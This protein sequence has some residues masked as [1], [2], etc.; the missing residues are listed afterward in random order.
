[1][2]QVCARIVFVFGISHLRSYQVDG[3]G[4]E[5]QIVGNYLM[6]KVILQR[7]LEENGCPNG[8]LITVFIIS[9]VCGV[10]QK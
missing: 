4:V 6:S 8:L 3:F 10:F 7:N 2:P 5:T 9:P 1:M